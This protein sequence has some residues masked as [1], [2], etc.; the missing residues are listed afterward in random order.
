MTKRTVLIAKVHM[1]AKQL[2]FDEDTYRTVLLTQTGKASCREMAD[3]QLSALADAFERLAAGKPLP[4]RD[5]LPANLHKGLGTGQPV[6]TR[7][8][9][10]ALEAL[11]VKAG[12]SGLQDFRLLAFVLH[13]AK[14]AD[15]GELT[16]ADI[17][18]VISGMSRRNTQKQKSEV[19]R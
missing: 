14:V 12:W 7:K 19:T 15:L 1:L 13:T 17:S 2:G 11:A 8:Q 3:K 16:R 18:K 6:P 5:A 10:A 9:W 4:D